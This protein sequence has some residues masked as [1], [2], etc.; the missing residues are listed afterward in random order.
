MKTNRRDALKAAILGSGLVGLKAI[1][2]G[3]PTWAFTHGLTDTR[4]WAAQPLDPKFL[5]LITSSQ[6]DVETRMI[7]L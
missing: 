4:A 5:L 2:T 7:I 3:L 6:G 1:A